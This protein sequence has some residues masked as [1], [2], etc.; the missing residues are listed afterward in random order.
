MCV[1]SKLKSPRQQKPSAPAGPVPPLESAEGAAGVLDILA[2]E[3]V[4]LLLTESGIL[5]TITASRACRRLRTLARVAHGQEELTVRACDDTIA[6]ALY[7]ARLPTVN[8][9]RV[10][11]A[12][13]RFELLALTKLRTPPGLRGKHGGHGGQ[14]PT[15]AEAMPP[16]PSPLAS[17]AAAAHGRGGHAAAKKAGAAPP[18][19]RSQLHRVRLA[20]TLTQTL[21]QTQNLTQTLTLTLTLTLTPTPTLTLTRG[22]WRGRTARGHRACWGRSPP[23]TWAPPSPVA[24]RVCPAALSR[25]PTASGRAC[26]RGLRASVTRRAC[27]RAGWRALRYSI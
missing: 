18:P 17:A 1:T 20:W 7:V 25:A 22:A 23:S 5:A 11:A 24:S 13:G 12:L 10:E 21:T 4:L 26:V 6:C 8:T 15:D 2:N 19:S 14:Q 3:L 9:L 27:A 16:L